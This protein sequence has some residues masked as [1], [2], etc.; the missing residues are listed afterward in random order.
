MAV[1][2]DRARTSVER[3]AACVAHE[4]CEEAK[5]GEAEA[6]S[7]S[8]MTQEVTDLTSLIR[9]STSTEE[10][11]TMVTSHSNSMERRSLSLDSLKAPLGED[12]TASSE[13]ASRVRGEGLICEVAWASS[14]PWQHRGTIKEAA[15]TAVSAAEVAA[16]VEEVCIREAQ[17]LNVAPGPER[18]RAM[19]AS[20]GTTT[21]RGTDTSTRS[22]LKS[23]ELGSPEERTLAA[24]VHR[25]TLVREAV[26]AAAKQ[27]N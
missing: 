8:T 3:L 10:E 22:T 19:V 21:R 17:T 11:A 4:G 6:T 20:T 27:R 16:T 18:T 14:R 15:I 1:A 2:T 23:Q 24:S 12:R 26:E 13:E 7:I 25:P 9:H 5:T